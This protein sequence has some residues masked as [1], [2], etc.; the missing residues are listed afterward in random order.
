MFLSAIHTFICSLQFGTKVIETDVLS[1]ACKNDI[2]KSEISPNKNENNNDPTDK[3]QTNSLPGSPTRSF[4]SPHQSR[5]VQRTD[6]QH[7]S[8]LLWQPIPLRTAPSTTLESIY[9]PICPGTNRQWG[10]QLLHQWPEVTA[11]I[12]TDMSIILTDLKLVALYWEKD[13]VIHLTFL[14]SACFFFLN[15][16]FHWPIG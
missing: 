9:D 11:K 16:E 8:P 12:N 6:R 3:T 1:L 2:H 7:Y 10:H 15:L 4:Q 13:E 5:Y 14:Y